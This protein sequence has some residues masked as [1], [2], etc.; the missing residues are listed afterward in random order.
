MKDLSLLP[1]NICSILT[2][3]S[4]HTVFLL[5]RLLENKPFR[6]RKFIDASS[7]HVILSSLCFRFQH[8]IQYRDLHNI[9]I[10]H[11]SMDGSVTSVANILASH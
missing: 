8:K 6:L 1:P 2:E 3:N 11:D 5:Y 10:E 9:N 4:V 7:K